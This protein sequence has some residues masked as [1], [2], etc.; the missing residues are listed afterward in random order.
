MLF[1]LDV[2][3]ENYLSFIQK[4]AAVMKIQ[5]YIPTTLI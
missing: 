5:L 3:L 4:Y 1:A 2:L